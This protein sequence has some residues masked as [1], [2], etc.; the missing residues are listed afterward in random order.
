MA[1][2]A[3]PRYLTRLRIEVTGTDRWGNRFK[4]TAFTHDISARG[5]RIT[6]VPPLLHPHAEIGLEYRG[7]RSR[8]RVVWVGGSASDEVGLLSLEPSRCIWGTPLPGQLIRCVNMVRPAANAVLQPAIASRPVEVAHSPIS[9]D[10][11]EESVMQQKR[12]RVGYFCKDSDCRKTRAFHFIT[13]GRVIWDIWP[14][15]IECPVSGQRYEYWKGDIRS[16]G[17]I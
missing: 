6:D 3:D 16:A 8:F 13:D 5:A 4:Q 9:S 12:K 1:N 10:P 2:R 15:K 14:Q 7:R 17:Y 11:A